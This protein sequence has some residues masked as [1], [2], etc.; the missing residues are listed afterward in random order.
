MSGDEG[1]L[2][3]PGDEGALRAVSGYRDDAD[4]AARDA[5]GYHARAREFAAEGRAASLVF[6]VAA[7]AME[8]YLM[9]LC[10]LHDVEPLHHTF[11]GLMSEVDALLDVPAALSEQ[12]AD[13]DE[14]FQICSLDD[15][16]RVEGAEADA[17]GAL[18]VCAG[19]ARVLT[20]QRTV[21]RVA[22]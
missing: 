12:I 18:E 8:R 20:A 22:A 14:M 10:Y 9:A 4:R 2:R 6:N 17:R 5:D 1:A 7:L 11:G 16:H 21:E 19:I 13:L 15:Y 3:R